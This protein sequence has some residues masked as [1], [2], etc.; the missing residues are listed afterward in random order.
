MTPETAVNQIRNLG[1]TA[2]VVALRGD[3]EVAVVRDRDGSWWA[4]PLGFLG[5]TI[6]SN[7]QHFQDIMNLLS[8]GDSSEDLESLQW[9]LYNFRFRFQPG[10][11][12][13]GYGRY[14][15]TSKEAIDLGLQ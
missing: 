4:L 7:L 15:L 6:A 9:E 8:E 2:E 11:A 10:L 3:P 12:G 5:E 13:D 1:G 14:I